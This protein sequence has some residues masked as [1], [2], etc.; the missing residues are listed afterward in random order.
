MGINV[1]RSHNELLEHETAFLD[2]ALGGSL[3]TSVVV[4]SLLLDVANLKLAVEFESTAQTEP[5]TRLETF[6]SSSS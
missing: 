6:M 4:Q 2:R 5:S 3:T 1:D